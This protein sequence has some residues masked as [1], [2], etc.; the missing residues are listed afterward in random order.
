MSSLDNN[1]FVSSQRKEA[2]TAHT[3]A[4]VIYIVRDRSGSWTFSQVVQFPGSPKWTLA[5]VGGH[6]GSVGE[7]SR[8]GSCLLLKHALDQD[9][10]GSVVLVFMASSCLSCPVPPAVLVSSASAVMGDYCVLV[11]HL[12]FLRRN[13]RHCTTSGKRTA[14]VAVVRSVLE[15]MEPSCGNCR[16]DETSSDLN[17]S[18]T[19]PPLHRG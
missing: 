19:A 5:S 9:W 14:Y 13:I 11:I 3:T 7:G 6:D 8:G 17:E 10:A 15:Y 2:A 18:N 1:K 16:I 12:G 4:L